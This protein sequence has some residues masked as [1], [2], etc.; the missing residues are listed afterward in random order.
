MSNLKILWPQVALKA[1]QLQSWQAFREDRPFD[2]LWCARRGAWAERAAATTDPIFLEFDQ[3]VGNTV[4]VDTLYLGGINPYL[5]SLS[6]VRVQGAASF[7]SLPP[8]TGT[9]TDI[10]LNA[11]IGSAPLVGVQDLDWQ[12]Q[13]FVASFT[14]SAAFRSIRFWMTP[15]SSLALYFSKLFICEAF[16]FDQDCELYTPELPIDDSL[17]WTSPAGQV[18]TERQNRPAREW[19]FTWDGVTDAKLAAFTEIVKY[20][21]DSS[22]A[23]YNPSGYTALLDGL[24]VVN[25]RLAE[26]SSEEISELSDYNRVIAKFQEVV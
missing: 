25:V 18:W 22:L 4:Q 17:R 19:S 23:L 6:S 26:W 1:V 11:A 24:S 14:L 15:S 12:K 16:D 2:N 13:D 7:S 9:G 10:Y 3:G 5:T 8:S 21:N 20:S